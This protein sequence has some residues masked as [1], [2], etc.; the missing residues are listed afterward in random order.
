[1]TKETNPDL[2]TVENVLNKFTDKYCY[3]VDVLG[4]NGDELIKI[5]TRRALEKAGLKVS[6]SYD[7]ADVIVFRGGAYINDLYPQAV[8]KVADILS[9]MPK[10]P[11]IIFPQSYIFFNGDITQLFSDRTKATY[12]FARERRSLKI[13]SELA[14]PPSVKLGIDHD[15]ALCLK[16][17]PLVHSLQQKSTDGHILIVEREDVEGTSGF[18][19]KPFPVPFVKK[20]FPADFR[21]NVKRAIRKSRWVKNTKTDYAKTALEE[22]RNR[23]SDIDGLPVISA[24]ISDQGTATFEEFCSLIANAAVVVTNRLHVGILSAMLGKRTLLREG[25]YHKISGVYEYSLASMPHVELIK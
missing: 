4:N 6:Y 19:H 8:T 14:F 12:L 18:V 23:W 10:C 20:L 17:D 21:M 25:S 7:D 1:M 11:V 3:L 9:K 22:V 5:G 2:L 16:D 13:L 15:T 24:D